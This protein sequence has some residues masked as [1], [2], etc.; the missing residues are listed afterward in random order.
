MW[1]NEV[2]DEIRKYRDEHAKKFNYDIKAICEDIRR[3]QNASGRTI[4]K[5]PLKPPQHAKKNARKEA[6]S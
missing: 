6:E 2:L 5:A 3:R 4:I 1:E